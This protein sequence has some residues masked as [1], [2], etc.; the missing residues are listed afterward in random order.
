MSQEYN[1]LNPFKSEST[2][3]KQNL[4]PCSGQGLH[5]DSFFSHQKVHPFDE[6][7][8]EKRSAKITSDNGQAIFEQDDIE[9]P[10]AWSQL[11]TKVVSSKY[12]YGD[13]QSGQRENSAKQ[14]VHRVSRT[15]ADRGLK[16]GYFATAQDA[17]NFYHDLTWLCIN[18]YGSFNSPVWFNVGL[19][20]VYD[21]P[22][23][24]HNFHWDTESKEAV[25]CDNS[26]EYPQA[27]ACFIQSV[28]DSM[29]DIMR[30]ATS[31]AMLF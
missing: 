29:E 24:K 20:D 22:G 3:P 31:E 1:P 16:D 19:Y 23:S 17:E 7:E 4:N 9:V 15:I 2:R 21:I 6:L 28:K 14:L 18:Q 5:L 26:Y 13:N 30:L 12:F 25:P 27:S 10:L 8:W 11:A